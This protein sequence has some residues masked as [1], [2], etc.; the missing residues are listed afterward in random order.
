[1][2]LGRNARAERTVYDEIR[3]RQ[4]GLEE[5]GVG[6]DTDIRAHAAKL[7]AEALSVRRALFLG[8]R[9]DVF[10]QRRRA[11]GRFRKGDHAL[12]TFLGDIRLERPAGRIADAV[13]HGQK[14]PLAGIQI[15]RLMGI[16]REGDLR[17][18]RFRLMDARGDGGDDGA[19]LLAAQRAGNEIALHIDDDEKIGHGWVPP[20]DGLKRVYSVR[21]GE[22]PA[23]APA[24]REN[25]IYDTLIGTKYERGRKQAHGQGQTV[26]K[27][28]SPP[29][30][31]RIT[32]SANERIDE[33]LHFS[34]QAK[35]AYVNK[36]NKPRAW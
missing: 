29:K 8:Q 9:A 24:L 31:G 18:F 15:I 7:D 6:D 16:Q 5:Q 14:A 2:L 4:S 36:L 3:L 34:V 10:T 25:G 26:E 27:S 13:R 20:D 30:G 12:R 23:A 1:M 19:R 21:G 17:L 28:D 35:F 32:L 11:E 33:L 22:N